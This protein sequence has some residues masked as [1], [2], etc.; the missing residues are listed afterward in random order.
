MKLLLSLTSVALLISVFYYQYS[1]S[2]ED[3]VNCTN[4]CTEVDKLK[5]DLT[6]REESDLS[7]NNSIVLEIKIPED[8]DI[9]PIQQNN[10]SSDIITDDS[11]VQSDKHTIQLN[12]LTEYELSKLFS[13]RFK[14]YSMSEYVSVQI[15]SVFEE[16]KETNWAYEAEDKIYLLAENLKKSR[17]EY[18]HVTLIQCSD[19]VCYMGLEGGLQNFDSAHFKKEL[20]KLIPGYF[21][22]WQL[23]S[24]LD[25]KSGIYFMRFLPF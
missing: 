12:A 8:V 17:S 24:N 9:V 3:N 7:E 5:R 20:E 6:T 11:V 18:Y 21:S 2:I 25:E 4:S 19:F 16:K 10:T 15:H 14:S 22:G 23:H 13:N 1:S